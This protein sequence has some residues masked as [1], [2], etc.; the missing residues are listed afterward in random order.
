VILE[1]VLGAQFCA[2][3]IGKEWPEKFPK[4]NFF[5]TSKKIDKHKNGTIILSLSL[6]FLNGKL[7]QFSGGKAN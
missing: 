4:K 3:T 2:D 5:P 7:W 6:F 1:F